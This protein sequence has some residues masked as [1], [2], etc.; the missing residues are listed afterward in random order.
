MYQRGIVSADKFFIVLKLSRAG[1][2]GEKLETVSEA[3]KRDFTRDDYT[4]ERISIG[5]PKLDELL[6]GGL[7]KNSITLISGSPGAGKS[8]LCFHFVNEGLK[9]GEKC[10]YITADQEKESILLYSK[11]LSFDFD[12]AIQEGL[13]DV[14]YVDPEVSGVYQR[15]EKA[16]SESNCERVVIDSLS[17][18]IDVP[19]LIERNVEFEKVPVVEKLSNYPPNSATVARHHIR[20]IFGMLRRYP[21]TAVVTSELPTEFSGLSRDGISEFLAD[22]VILMQIDPMMDRRKLTIWKM[23]G[24]K[25]TLRPVD[26]LITDRGIEIK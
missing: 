20:K 13:L 10:L 18:F 21:A 19:I 14:L 2:G 11:S 5:I 8:I 16:I 25:H 6:Q 12:K 22:G 23:R 26:I 4:L 1:E 24:T 9:R 3:I 17:Q 7:P 15:M